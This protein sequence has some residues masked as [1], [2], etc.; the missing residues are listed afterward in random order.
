MT[1]CVDKTILSNFATPSQNIILLE[2]QICLEKS[3]ENLF[4]FV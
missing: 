1:F 4:L 3:T 2:A